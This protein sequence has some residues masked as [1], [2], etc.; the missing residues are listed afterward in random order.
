MTTGGPE[1]MVRHMVR[2]ANAIEFGFDFTTVPVGATAF[3]ASTSPNRPHCRS[4][5][6]NR[7]ESDNELNEGNRISI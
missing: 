7:Y 1:C 6:S 3:A 2:L 4:C 5:L